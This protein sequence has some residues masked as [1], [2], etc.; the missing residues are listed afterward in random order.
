MLIKTEFCVSQDSQVSF[1]TALIEA[2]AL[3]KSVGILE[4]KSK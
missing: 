2:S 4:L 1:V 3:D